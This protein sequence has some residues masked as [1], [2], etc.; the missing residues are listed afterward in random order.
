MR[1]R[2]TDATK[3]KSAIQCIEVLISRNYIRNAPD[4]LYWTLSVYSLENRPVQKNRSL[5]NSE[6]FHFMTYDWKRTIQKLLDDRKVAY[7]IIQ[8]FS[9]DSICSNA[10]VSP[11]TTLEDNEEKYLS[12][13]STLSDDLHVATSNLMMRLDEERKD[14]ILDEKLS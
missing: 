1:E 3:N 10:A 8:Y 9:A 4:N 14:F 2:N 11:V 7:S 5:Q 12:A 6:I 13:A